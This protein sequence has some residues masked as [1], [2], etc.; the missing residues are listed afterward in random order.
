MDKVKVWIGLSATVLIML[1][2]IV[3]RSTMHQQ[4]LAEFAAAQPPPHIPPPTHAKP[5]TVKAEPIIIFKKVIDSAAVRRA[6]SLVAVIASLRPD[7]TKLIDAVKLLAEPWGQEDM[8]THPWV[9][10]KIITTVEPAIK[11]ALPV[12]VLDSVYVPPPV[13]I[14]DSYLD[15]PWMFVALLVGI[16]GGLYY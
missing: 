14:V 4:D 2:Y 16:L 5:D 9:W 1:G 13:H 6:D 10:G 8:I 11:R 12:L 15:W 7:S 3:G